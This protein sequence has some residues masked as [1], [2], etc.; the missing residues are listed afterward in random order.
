MGAN[1]AITTSRLVEWTEIGLLPDNVI[2]HGIRRL[3]KGRLE[4]VGAFDCERVAQG[5][6]RFISMMDASEIA[7]VPDRAN[8]Q[9][10]EV[11]AEFFKQVLGHRLKYSCGYWPADVSSLDDAETAALSLTGARAQLTDG[12]SVLD[13]G[14]GWGSF[15]LWGAERYPNSRFTA[16]SN[17][18]GQREAI[19]AEAERRGLRNLT[20]LTRDMNEF[21]PGARFDR[22]VS[23]EM[24][25]HMRNYRRLFE[26]LSTWLNPEGRFLMHIFCHRSSAYEFVD[27]SPSDWMARHFFAGGIMPSD[28]L[29]SR[30]Q[31][32]LRLMNHW[33]WDGR[34]YERTANAWLQNMDERKAAIMPIMR[35][36][37]GVEHAS[38][39]WM[40]WRIF[41]M[42]CAELFGYA[43]GQ[44]WWVSHYLFAPRSRD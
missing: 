5:R 24:F 1:V 35:A 30:F 36:T 27:E 26:R 3:L 39:W 41:F 31:D 38:Q 23:I 15:S 34:H 4:D 8:D 22:I 32:H 11:P 25:E 14:C 37:Y 43:D 10:Y 12:Q 7:P 13:L 6:E 33:R 29:P 40:R 19:M 20:V 9:H 44:Q 21:D 28:D 2:R 42:A 17:S 18:R 16:V